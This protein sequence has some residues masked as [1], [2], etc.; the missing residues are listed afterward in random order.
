MKNFDFNI[1]ADYLKAIGANI[2]E[3]N[4]CANIVRCDLP[5]DKLEE[6]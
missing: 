3:I 5:K 1:F 6:I 4:S 2:I